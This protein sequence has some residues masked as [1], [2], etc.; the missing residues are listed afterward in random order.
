MKPET[1]LTRIGRPHGGTGLVNPAVERGSTVLAD[2]AHELYNAPPGKTHYGRMGLSAQ[3]ALRD[4][5]CEISGADWCALTPSGLSAMTLP[6]L[7]VVSNGGRVLAADC[8]YGPTRKFLTEVLPR[9]GVEIEFFPP[10]MGSGI[11]SLMDERVQAVFLESPGSLTFELQDIPAISAEARKVGAVVITDDTYSAGWLM[12]PLDLGADIAAQA[13]TKYV[14]GHSDILLGAALA[15]G[16][17]ADRL[18]DYERTF[19]CHV[20]PDDAWMAL[21]GLRTLAVRMT[22]SAESALKI[23]DWLSKRPEIASVIHPAR[24]DHPDHAIFERD[25][26]GAS[27]LFAVTLRDFD[28]Q[29]T[30]AFLDALQIFGLGFSW[31]GYESLAIHC[32]PQLR[33]D[34]DAPDDGALVR[35]GIGLE[36]PDDLIADLEKGFAAIAV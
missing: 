24:T 8:V 34:H 27:G 31:G 12:K 16:N 35:F 17:A 3:S 9:Y 33:R 10:R 6:L 4:A 7:A 26:S 29:R 11:A 15:R 23:A 28:R 36:D 18:K 21:R 32:G 20:S 1:R 30:E 14:G 2:T 25:F 22:R 13:L 19:G 5:L